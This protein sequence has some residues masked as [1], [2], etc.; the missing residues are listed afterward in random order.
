MIARSAAK[1]RAFTLIE[2]LVVISII[3]VLISLLL[4]AV[5]SAR[6]AA[7]KAQCFNN[8]RQIGLGMHNYLS[9]NDV[10]P[11]GGLYAED[12][13]F[14]STGTVLRSNYTGWAVAILS[15]VEQSPL[16]NAYNSLLNNWDS[17]N[18]TVISTTLNMYICPS[19][20]LNQTYFPTFAVGG[21]TTPY[22]NIAPGSYKG[23][24]G[25]YSTPSAGTELFWDYASYVRDLSSAMQPESRGILTV[26]GVGGIS[27]VRISEISDGTSNTLMVG[28]YAT[29]VAANSRALWPAS[30]GYM[31][32]GSA[33]P[34]Q[35][36]RGLPDYALCTTYIAAN[37]C[38]RAFASFHPN[39]MNFVMGD[40]SVKTIKRY[41]DAV[42]YQNLATMRGGEIISAEAF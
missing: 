12:A 11:A 21:G 31:S 9:T 5:Q 38:N 26:A 30:W 14:K 36:V 8:L 24:A 18:G 37:R 16:F 15:F 1:V 17:S 29:K 23:V 35:G 33:G 4:P 13:L 19:D 22:V 6:E 27:N 41:I 2:L 10:F 20:I 7:R 40:G 3:A 28:E 42:I 25:R 39:V 34:S 32:L